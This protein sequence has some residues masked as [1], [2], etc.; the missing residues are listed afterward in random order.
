MA[1]QQLK[2]RLKG[3]HVQVTRAQ[4]C[5]TNLDPVKERLCSAV[6]QHNPALSEKIATSGHSNGDKQC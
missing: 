4:A 1:L 2:D 3:L 6:Q 5:I